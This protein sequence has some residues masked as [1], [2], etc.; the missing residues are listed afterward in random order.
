MLNLNS[1]IDLDLKKFFRWWKRELDFL[2]PEKIREII[3]DNRGTII[4]RPE[5]EQFDL[6]F[7]LDGQVEHL[8]KLERTEVGGAQYKALVESNERLQKADLIFRLSSR[9]G[10]Q[11]EIALPAAAKENLYQVVS[12]ELSRYSPYSTDQAYF[13]VKQLK[14]VNDPDHI[15]VLLILTDRKILDAY[16][17]D[18]KMMAMSPIY[19][20]YEGEPNAIEDDD[21]HYNLLPESLCYK[22]S[23][24]PRIIYS[25]LGGSLLL[26]LLAV[27]AIPVWFEFQA[28]K[29]LEN[30]IIP[31]EKEAKKIKA[32]QLEID[33]LIDETSKL[34]GQKNATPAVLVMLNTLSTLIKDDTWLT[35]AQ[36]ADGHLQIQGES[37]AASNLISV[38]EASELFVNAR[39]ISPV[40]QDN[41]SKLE[42]FQITVDTSLPTAADAVNP[43]GKMSKNGGKN[44]KHN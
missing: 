37:P 25:V 8:V 20:D 16:Y 31:I 38:L 6:S 24:A 35:Y 9:S 4:V 10:I 13:A 18:L 1:T 33:S 21:A 17:D 29:E 41:V 15:R 11:K 14:G 12:Y 22:P 39:F 2:I 40:T 32:L 23:N 44:G 42:R 30:K 43:D 27:L 36:Y 19:V 5:G 3:N 26:L 7:V 28:V 34:I